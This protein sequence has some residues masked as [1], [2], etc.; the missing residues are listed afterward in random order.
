VLL[1]VGWWLDFVVHELRGPRND[2]TDIVL[3]SPAPTSTAI[4]EAAE[5]R[6]A[7]A[8]WHGYSLLQN[9]ATMLVVAVA[10][11]QAARM[12]STVPPKD[13]SVPVN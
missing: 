5:A 9:F 1:G 4:R 11:A 3:R 8:I 13:Y 10:L 6:K 7:F 12:P 2:K